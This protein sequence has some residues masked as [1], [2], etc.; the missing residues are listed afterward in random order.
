[1]DS[2]VFVKLLNKDKYGIGRQEFLGIHSLFLPPKNDPQFKS[3]K[4]KP[5]TP[6]NFKLYNYYCD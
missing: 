5:L 4:N 1:M 2:S 3:K 6:N